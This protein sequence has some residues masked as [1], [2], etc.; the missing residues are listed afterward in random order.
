[1]Q[2]AYLVVSKP[3]AWSKLHCLLLLAVMQARRL[4]VLSS[5]ERYTLHS[6]MRKSGFK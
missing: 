6:R 5:P 3:W 2:A 1:M 4:K